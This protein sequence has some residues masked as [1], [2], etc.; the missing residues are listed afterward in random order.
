MFAILGG[1]IAEVTISN[2]QTP[3]FFHSYTPIFLRS[4]TSLVQLRFFIDLD[5]TEVSQMINMNSMFIIDCNNTAFR[6]AR[7]EICQTRRMWAIS[8]TGSVIPTIFCWS[9]WSQDTLR[10]KGTEKLILPSAGGLD[11]KVMLHAGWEL[12]CAILRNYNLPQLLLSILS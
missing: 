8:R 10:F 11:G 9:K 12:F 6:K 5:S 2:H 7:H 1:G 4:I 3:K